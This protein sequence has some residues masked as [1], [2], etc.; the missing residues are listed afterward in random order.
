VTLGWLEPAAQAGK[1]GEL[2]RFRI[3]EPVDLARRKS[4]M[5]PIINSEI[6][7]E[8]VSIYNARVLPRYPLNGAYLTN[9]TG[10]EMLAGPV[11]VLDEDMYAGDAQID[12]FTPKDK[13]LI[14][15]AVDLS[16]RVDSSGK[17]AADI[18]G[19]KIVRGV[20]EV[21]RKEVKTQEYLIKNKADE[22][23]VVIIEHPYNPAEKLLTPDK[24]EDRT[25]HLY[26]FRVGVAK[27][28]TE[29]FAVVTERVYEQ[30]FAILNYDVGMLVWF[31]KNA[32][33]SPSVRDALGRA[34]AMRQEL[35]ELQRKL[36]KL[37]EQKRSLAL[38][39]D[40][41]RKNLTSAGRDSTLGKR[42]L[43]K[44]AQQE[45]EFERLDEQ[46]AATREAIEATHKKL[47]DYLG[48]LSID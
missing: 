25:E 2:F 14:S 36:S 20:L 27:D 5:L 10:A 29:K 1:V 41:L 32:R 11:T 33:L 48:K 13:R 30:R 8:K 12:H 9:D 28:K 19:A 44:M 3:T 35:A 31:Q 43:S 17:Q 34:I 26:R 47:A 45:D 16:V 6:A 40:R 18:S 7:A 24:Y 22:K 37:T 42:Y 46:I 38:D 23:R 39:Q 15:Y 4:A 21:T